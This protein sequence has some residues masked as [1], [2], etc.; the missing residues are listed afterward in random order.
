MRRKEKYSFQPDLNQ[1]P[2]DICFHT[3]YSPPLYQ[4]TRRSCGYPIQLKLNKREGAGILKV[5]DTGQW[6]RGP[7][8]S[9]QA[10]L[11]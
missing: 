11:I 1:R 5:M 6:K 8:D 10:W 7:L 3:I 9:G 2:M 4:H